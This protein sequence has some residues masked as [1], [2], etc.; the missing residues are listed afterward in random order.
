MSI[1]STCPYIVH[2]IILFLLH[3]F[4]FSSS[5][6][7]ARHLE[8]VVMMLVAGCLTLDQIRY[9]KSYMD[10]KWGGAMF[11]M[12]MM[13]SRKLGCEISQFILFRAGMDPVFYYPDICSQ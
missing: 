4:L 7:T 13:F 11:D 2:T 12:I 5:F 6:Q 10:V 8:P 9:I 3:D 1:C